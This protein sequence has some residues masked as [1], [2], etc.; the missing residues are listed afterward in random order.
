MVVNKEDKPKTL[1]GQIGKTLVNFMKVFSPIPFVGGKLASMGKKLVGGVQEVIAEQ[2]KGLHQ[3]S[4]ASASV[5]AKSAPSIKPVKP[6]SKPTTTVAYD[7]QVKSATAAQNNAG[8][9]MEL[10]PFNPATMR[11]ASKIRTLGITV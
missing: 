3:S 4:E 11:S 8:P 2:H 6:P 1:S 10:P 9:D 5:I 7:K